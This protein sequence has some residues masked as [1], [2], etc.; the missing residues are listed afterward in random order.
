[1][2]VV[3]GEIPAPPHLSNNPVVYGHQIT[4][5]AYNQFF[6]RW[7]ALNQGDRGRS[8]EVWGASL[9]QSVSAR[10]ALRAPKSPHY[11]RLSVTRNK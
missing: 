4:L 3:A 11:C 2:L 7:T 8:G 6:R 9:L 1:M 10:L 5:V